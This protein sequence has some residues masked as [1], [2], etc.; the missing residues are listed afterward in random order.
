MV[1]LF[2]S[3]AFKAMWNF[4]GVA[5]LYSKS[6][7]NFIKVVNGNKNIKLDVMIFDI[8]QVKKDLDGLDKLNLKTKFKDKESLKALKDILM[9]VK[10]IGNNLKKD[11][12]EIQTS[13][14]K[15]DEL[16][17]DLNKKFYK[18]RISRKKLKETF[19][20]AT[21]IMR[22]HIFDPLSVQ[23]SRL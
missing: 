12:P 6:L 19:I 23:L 9:R 18:D 22:Y 7:W 2:L 4:G 10:E 8:K 13:D 21:D 17:T 1:F 14:F 20:Y 11:Y 5:L 3:Q 16:Y 15:I